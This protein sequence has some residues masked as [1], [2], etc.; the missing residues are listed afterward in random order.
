M[1]ASYINQEFFMKVLVTGAEGLLGRD[2]CKV[3]SQ[4][5]Y[6]VKPFSHAA[7][8]ITSVENVTRVLNE[9]KPEVVI[10]CAAYTNVDAAEND[11]ETACR[12]NEKGTQNV[13]SWCAENDATLVYIS[14]DYVFYGG[15]ER[16]YKP[17]DTTNPINKFGESKRLGEEVV[18]RTCKKYY[19]VRTSW[20]Y[21]DK[22]HNFV[23]DL[24][25]AS[26][27]A[28]LQVVDDQKGSPTWTCDVA[29]ALIK[30]LKEKPFGIYHACNSGA[31]TWY[32]L[33]VK[34]YDLLGVKLNLKPCT[35]DLLRNRVAKRPVQS[36][37]DN[38]GLCR[39]WEEALADFV[40][41]LKQ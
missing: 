4:Q 13:A 30:I 14:T 36:V 18:K 40:N 20:L 10:H 19:I 41:T 7:L 11:F 5:G 1:K 31:T 2:V 32:G 35:S 34:L 33:A 3:F 25:A 8:D 29:L 21:G 38:G 24:I 6:A 22:P 16:A 39:P 17:E 26:N 27:N 28:Q 9:E 23:T 37:L 15:L 12:V